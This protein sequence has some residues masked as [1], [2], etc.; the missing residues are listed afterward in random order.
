[1]SSQ[2]ERPASSTP[3]AGATNV[4]ELDSTGTEA[5]PAV[6]ND[7]LTIYLNRNTPNGDIFVSTRISTAVPFSIPAMVPIVDTSADELNPF[8]SADGL[9]LLVAPDW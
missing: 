2:P 3:P 8:L 9:T 4:L 5:G 1:M 7:L 6:T